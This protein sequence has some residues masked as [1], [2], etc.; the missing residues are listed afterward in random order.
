MQHFRFK[1]MSSKE[2]NR[3]RSDLFVIAGGDDERYAVTTEPIDY[4]L[5][6]GSLS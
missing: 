1:Y 2:I 6:R 5:G 3:V 4:M